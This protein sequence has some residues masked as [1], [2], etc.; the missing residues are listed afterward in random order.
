MSELFSKPRKSPV[1]G[2]AILRPRTGGLEGSGAR[3]PD[4]PS[5]NCR[6][7]VEAYCE[8]RDGR[9][10]MPALTA[11]QAHMASCEACRRYDRVIRTGVSVLRAGEAPA[12]SRTLGVTRIRNRAWAMENR[13]SVALGSAGSGMTTLGVALVAIVLGSVAWLPLFGPG[14]SS[15]ATPEFELAPVVAAVR[16]GPAPPRPKIGLRPT[17]LSLS[18]TLTRPERPSPRLAISDRLP[19]RLQREGP[20]DDVIWPPVLVQGS[21]WFVRPNARGLAAGVDPD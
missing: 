5:V 15:A 11:V 6:W 13:E 3:S 19:F 1:P 8:Y 2:L 20:T 21:S 7:F 16:E 4:G 10:T 12:R 17:R 18:T 9:L 14:T